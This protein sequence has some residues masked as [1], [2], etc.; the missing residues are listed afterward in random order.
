VKEGINK[1]ST[2]WGDPTCVVADHLGNVFEA[3]SFYGTIAFGTNIVSTSTLQG[4]AY[5]VKYDSSGNILW[6]QYGTTGINDIINLFGASIDSAGNSF[7]TG[8]FTDSICFG[9]YK[10]KTSGALDTNSFIVKLDPTGNALWLKSNNSSTSN[11]N[12]ESQ[13][14]S[15][16][17]SGN[18]I[19]TG[20]FI[21]TVS[22]GSYILTDG[23]KKGAP[24]IVKYDPNGNVLWA[25]GIKTQNIHGGNYLQIAGPAITCDSV[26][27]IYLT[28]YYYDTITFGSYTFTSG[29]NTNMYL[30]KYDS[31]GNVK[32]A[33][34]AILPSANCAAGTNVYYNA[35]ISTDRNC[36]IYITGS[37]K[38]SIE[39]GSH[40]L[41]NGNTKFVCKYNYTTYT[42][43]GSAFI[44]K[45]DSSGKVILAESAVPKNKSCIS[46]GYSVSINKWG[47][48]W[49]G[50]MQDTVSFGKVNLASSSLL[51]SFLVKLDTNAQ[52]LCGTTIKN[53]NDDYNSVAA[54]PRNNDVYFTGDAWANSCVFG[55]DTLY[56]QSEWAFL[57]KWQCCGITANI[58]TSNS[59]ICAGQGTTL[60]ASGG[61][62]YSWNNG[63][64][65]ATIN[66]NPL[67]TES[68]KVSVSNGF[69]TVK[70]SITIPVIPV[71]IISISGL[72]TLCAGSSTILSAKGGISYIWNNGSTSSS[73]M[74]NPSATSTYLVMVS[75][76]KCSTR[77]SITVVVNPF[78]IITACCDST[79]KPGQNVQLTS[80]GGILYLWQP[81]N[82][83]N[84]ANCSNPNASPVEST[85]YTVTV[86]SDSGCIAQEFITIDVSC[87][88]IFIPTAFSPNGDGQNDIL[89]VRGDCIKTL[90]FEVFD[91][92]G[93]RVFLT[94]DKN[95]GWNGMYRGQAMNTGSYV[96]YL[97]A[98]M[99]DG[100]TASKK[101]NVALV[102]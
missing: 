96:Y 94:S 44:V 97:T 79:I 25:K 99:Y 53:L 27:A 57:A 2:S 61:S 42:Y 30:V 56:G 34:S 18:S 71:P 59:N 26:G 86:T 64:T 89:Y 35:G 77:D 1:T 52:A 62:S 40:L 39:F 24:F 45:F 51:P 73:I 16:D 36:N 11:T 93:N 80:S 33:K 72:T 91:R 21:D 8:Y 15:T 98:T 66:I 47:V 37:Y 48:Y 85:T 87:G 63:D 75:D 70:D 55:S 31:S 60:T 78:P 69:C 92:W 76:G 6:T 65:S 90:Q 28:G 58:L 29:V 22:F 14:I 101:G 32:W 83:L 100:T 38:D 41:T 3:G 95:I 81:S 13:A 82:S 102:R 84:C 49:C 20:N 88:T 46:T 12:C 5:V 54:D 9:P 23:G 68:F 50:T 4:V 67:S 10:L 43:I 7:L 74:V 19:I 17:K